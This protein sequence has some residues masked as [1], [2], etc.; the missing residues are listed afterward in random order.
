MWLVLAAAMLASATDAPP[1][2]GPAGGVTFKSTKT[3]D[4]LERCLSDKL[5]DVGE[6]VAVHN[7]LNSTTLVVRDI[8]EGPMTIELAP[9][10]CGPVDA[11]APIA[12]ASAALPSSWRPRKCIVQA[13]TTPRRRSASMAS[14]GI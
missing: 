3:L 12:T 14:A 4:A 13:L 7:E 8:P 11:G 2:P 10:G 5:A 1:A 9:S 6:V